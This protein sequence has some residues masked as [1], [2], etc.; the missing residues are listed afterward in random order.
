M[1]EIKNL[2]FQQKNKA[3]FVFYHQSKPDLLALISSTTIHACFH[4]C[5]KGRVHGTN[6]S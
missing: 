4:K 5:R 2:D 3:Y 1:L 6:H